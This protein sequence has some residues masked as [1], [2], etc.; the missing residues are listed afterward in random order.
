[1]TTRSKGVCPALWILA[2]TLGHHTNGRPITP[3]HDH[4]GGVCRHCGQHRTATA[5][6]KEK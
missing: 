6:R 3:K 4:I 2:G 1:M 5:T